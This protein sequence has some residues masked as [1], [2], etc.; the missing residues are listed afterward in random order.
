MKERTL[1]DF[2]TSAAKLQKIE[3]AAL[4]WKKK[5]KSR[6]VPKKNLKGGPFGLVLYCM[7]RGKP[8]WF[9]SLGQ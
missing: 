3:G 9:S 8:F 1:W 2:S 7:L 6:T 4:W 5:E